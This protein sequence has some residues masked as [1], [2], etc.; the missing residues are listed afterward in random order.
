MNKSSL[1]II[2][3]AA[4]L[5]GCATRSGHGVDRAN[6]D[7]SVEPGADFYD[8]ACGGWMKA[9]PLTPEYSR[10]GTFDQLGELNREQVRD[11]VLGLD[12]STAEKG[13]N[14]QKIADLYAMAEK[15]GVKPD[16]GQQKQSEPIFKMILKA[17]IGRDIYDNATYFKVYNTF[18]PIFRKA[19]EIINSD[20]Y[21]RI[22]STGSGS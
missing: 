3:L 7:T 4:A 13:S 14:T 20:E 1:A 19:F 21:D 18:D 16:S 8:Y 2:A 15:D 9:N 6:L 11:L 12:A 5:T 10:Y 22:L 17:L